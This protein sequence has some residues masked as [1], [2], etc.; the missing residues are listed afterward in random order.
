MKSQ[1]SLSMKYVKRT[2]VDGTIKAPASKSMMQRAVAAATLASGTTEILNPSLCSDGK[3]SLDAA[4]VLGAVISVDN[5][6]VTVE[7]GGSPADNTLNCGESG[8]CLRMFSP[9]AALFDDKFILT[10]SGSLLSRP[11][12]MIPQTLE[13]LGAFCITKTGRLPLEITGPMQGGNAE[14][15]GS[16]TSQF[17]TGLLMALPLCQEDSVLTVKNLK[18]RPYVSMTLSL[19][20]KFG[21]M[22]HHDDKFEVFKIPGR[23]KYVPGVFNIE[24]DWS[25]A[26][27][28]L[29]AG[30][31]AG[32]ITVTNLDINSLQADRVILDA[33]EMAGAGIEIGE[34][35]ITIER[36]ELNGFEFEASECP[37]LF[38]PLAALAC[39]CKGK[40]IIY[41][42]ERLKHKESSRGDVLVSELG[43]MGADVRVEN[44]RMEITGTELE[45]G[46]VDSHNDHRIAMACAC[47]GL[48]SKNGVTI[49]N[50]EAISKS[51]PEFFEDL[52]SVYI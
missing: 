13:K 14:V 37:D 47:A 21:I 26:A 42:T 27:F 25:G 6:K 20:R 11:V 50:P 8:L 17:L 1:E 36:S 34:N 10:G 33:L 16:V 43:A 41:G 45:G 32:K 5:E 28:L 49:R 30:A 38:P 52:E 22:I 15:D 2:E 40:T 29:V 24:G 4:L 7:G 46:I 18:S 3:A 19:L 39:S 9:I 12:D 23:Q 48:V 31:I 44:N 51:Y 35:S